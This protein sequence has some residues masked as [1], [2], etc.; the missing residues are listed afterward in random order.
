M[1]AGYIC[2]HVAAVTNY[3]KLGSLKQQKL[4]FLQFERLDVQNQGVRSVSLEIT[5]Q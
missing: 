3:H 2:I 1:E 4:I 5:S